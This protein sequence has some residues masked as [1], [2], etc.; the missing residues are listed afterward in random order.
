MS[1]NDKGLDTMS[2]LEVSSVLSC[3]RGASIRGTGTMPVTPRTSSA[4]TSTGASGFIL[5]V[6]GRGVDTAL[7]GPAFSGST[8]CFLEGPSFSGS[9]LCLLGV[10][11]FDVSQ[12]CFGF[13]SLLS[14]PLERCLFFFVI[15]SAFLFLALLSAL[16]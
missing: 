8:L 3:G 4:R 1:H 11:A 9:T 10:L 13:F 15:F 7:A 14:I 16:D 12:C 5:E 6:L 2:R